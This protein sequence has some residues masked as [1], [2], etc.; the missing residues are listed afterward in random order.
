MYCTES[1]ATPSDGATPAPFPGRLFD[2]ARSGRYHSIRC[3][4]PCAGRRLSRGDRRMFEDNVVVPMDPDR[5]HR[6][7]SGQ[8]TAHERCL[9]IVRS[10][11]RDQPAEGRML[12]AGAQV[13]GRW[14]HL[15]RAVLAGAEG[16]Q[17]RDHRPDV[18]AAGQRRGAALLHA[19]GAQCTA[20]RLG[21]SHA[22][23]RPA[24]LCAAIGGRRSDLELANLRG[25]LPGVVPEPGGQGAE[26]GNGSHHHPG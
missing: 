20:P 14:P 8:H 23:A 2:E 4:G 11:Y 10:C 3:G 21:R 7:I 16:E 5:T 25:S 18:A 12:V 22:D 9:V 19:R 6:G 24:C 15:G 17:L 26:A 1:S 13:P